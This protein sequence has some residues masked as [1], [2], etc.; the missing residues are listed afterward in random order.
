M[1][2]V[3][4]NASIDREGC[5]VMH[6]GDELEAARRIPGIERLCASVIQAR[7]KHDVYGFLPIKPSRP[8]EK[9]IGFGIFQVKK[10][11][12]DCADP[13][14]IDYSMECLRRYVTANR[15]LKIRMNYPGVGEGGL[16]A[17]EIA[18]LIEPLPENVTVC[19][20]GEVPPPVYTGIAS[21][22][23]LYLLVERWLQEGRY[24]LAVEYLMTN[25]YEQQDALEQVS[26]VQRQMRERDEVSSERKWRHRERSINR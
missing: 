11:W 22:K 17:H 6:Q 14:I 4:A 12:N 3:T 26:A 1:I 9:I 8:V 25:G 18:P 15:G 16:A 19:H 10:N 5:L 2:V 13:Q 23:D 24:N 21:L 20:R 7:S